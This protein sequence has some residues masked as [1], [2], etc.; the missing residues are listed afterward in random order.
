MID[1]LDVF[2]TKFVQCNNCGVIHKVTDVCKSEI[3][4]GREAM[5]SIIS[6]D[7]IKLTLPP[8]LVTILQTHNVDLP[9]WEAAQFVYENKRWGEFVILTTD[10]EEGM[11][12][13]KFIRILGENLFKVEVFTREEYVKQ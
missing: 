4:Q 12:Q 11:K 6:I 8:N 5:S 7:D 3:L 10:F 9:T 1:D 13:G 2:Q